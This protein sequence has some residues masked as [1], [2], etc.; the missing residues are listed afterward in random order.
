MGVFI[1]CVIFLVSFKPDGYFNPEVVKYRQ[2][3]A[4]SQ[5]KRRLYS[6]QQ[7]YHRLL[8]QILV[9]RKVNDRQHLLTVTSA[10]C[11]KVVQNCTTVELGSIFLKTIVTICRVLLFFF[12]YFSTFSTFSTLNIKKLLL[13]PN[14]TMMYYLSMTLCLAV[15][16]VSV[17]THI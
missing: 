7:Y 1:N 9:S 10:V 15:Y 13:F 6:L 2:L 16:I 12:F 11:T 17:V 3:C 14:F 8:K 4:K 5:R